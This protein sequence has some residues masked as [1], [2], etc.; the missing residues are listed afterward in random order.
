MHT[1]TSH[2]RT[3]G[4]FS[5]LEIIIAMSIIAI[6]VGVVGFRSGSAIQRGHASRL[7]QFI[8]GMEKACAAHYADT[9]RH[10]REY[11]ISFAASNRMLSTEQPTNGWQGPYIERPFANNDTNPF[12]VARIYNAFNA[13]SW[14]TGFDM[15]GDGTADQTGT[16]S[17]LYLTNVPEEVVEKLDASFDGGIPGD[18]KA[19]GRVIWQDTSNRVLVYLYN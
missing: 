8:K 1:R 9:G 5:L 17:M 14:I 4:G 13:N 11:E 12:G 3:R 6:L 2:R 7:T 16:G 10:A 15:D 18:W 19:T